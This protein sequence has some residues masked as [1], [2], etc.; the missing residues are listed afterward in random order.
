[1]KQLL[2]LGLVVG[3]FFFVGC[4]YKGI[5]HGEEI[6]PEQVAT[7]ENGKTTKKDIYINFG[8]PTKTMDNDKVFF[9]TWTRGGKGHFLGFGSGSAE[10]KS[11]VVVFNDRD[12]VESHKITRGATSGG[13]AIGD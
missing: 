1:M 10:S 6:T 4:G 5:K 7:I 3:V 12:V 2:C 11:L 9:Y 8:D 13:A